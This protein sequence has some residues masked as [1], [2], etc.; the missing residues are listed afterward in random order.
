MCFFLRARS[1]GSLCLRLSLGP[2]RSSRRC[3]TIG[4]SYSMSCQ[5][6]SFKNQRF[7]NI[8]RPRE[9]PGNGKTKTNAFSTFSIWKLQKPTCFVS[10]FEAKS[11]KT[12]GFSVVL[13]S[14]KL[15]ALPAGP[16]PGQASPAW[17]FGSS[18]YCAIRIWAASMV[19][20]AALATPSGP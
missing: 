12:N 15:A 5:H 16:K 19:E 17:P 3:R 20:R 6:G 4:K 7:F 14:G 1:K 11:L 9:V 10:H 13:A 2:G 18:W 8:L